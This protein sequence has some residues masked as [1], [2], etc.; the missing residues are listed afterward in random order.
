[1]GDCIYCGKPAGLFKTRHKE[2]EERYKMAWRSMVETSKNAALGLCSLENLTNE[3]HQIAQQGFVP[4]GKIK[5]ALVAGWEQAALHFLSDGNLSKEEEEKLY[6]FAKFFNLEQKDLDNNGFYTKVVQAGVLR[7]IMEGKLPTRVVLDTHLP[8]NFQK[9]ETLVWVFQNVKYFE[10]RVKHE[11]V[12]GTQGVSIRI[13]KGI[14]YRIGGFKGYPVEKTEVV[15]IDTGIMAVTDKHIYF[16]GSLRSF[17]IPYSKIVSF[18]PYSDGIGI[19]RDAASAKPQI[20]LTGDG[21]FVYN[22]VTNL[23]RR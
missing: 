9:G 3:L 23:A 12:G 1:M 16:H 10:S 5:N 7:D 14:Y 2:C 13:A 20:F 17:R 11:Y 22:L 4:T 21:W 8:F 15:H 19:Q 18:Q 6:N